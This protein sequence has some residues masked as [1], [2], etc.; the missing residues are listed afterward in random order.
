M[1]EVVMADEQIIEIQRT[2]T[3]FGQLVSGC[4]ATV[5]KKVLTARLHDVR[6]AK[7]IGVG[8]RSARTKDYQL[9]QFKP[10]LVLH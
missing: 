8:N 2:K 5:E 9:R 6:S 10:S 4:R 1:I 7:S 3:D